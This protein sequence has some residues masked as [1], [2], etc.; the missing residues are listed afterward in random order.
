MKYVTGDISLAPEWIILH[1]CNMQGKM[2]SGVAKALRDRFPGIYDD[3]IRE[4]PSK[5]LGDAIQ[6]FAYL[7][8]GISGPPKF[9]ANLLTQEF[10]G[11][12]GSAFA[13]LNAIKTSIEWVVD[14]HTRSVALMAPH[15]E[16]QQLLQIATP[17]IGCGRGGL[18][19]ESDV[20]P[21]YE[22]IESR[23]NIEFIVYDMPDKYSK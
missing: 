23:Y 13:D 5:K 7:K 4:L 20:R 8:K 15:D 1:G 19:W 12:D 3:Y 22:D 11:Y 17:K 9:I 14:D 10:Y 2:N 6:S 16:V 18:S 21:I